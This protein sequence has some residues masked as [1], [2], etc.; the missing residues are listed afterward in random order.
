MTVEERDD[1]DAADIVENCECRDED[2]EGSRD[3]ILE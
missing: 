1:E 2:D 3:A